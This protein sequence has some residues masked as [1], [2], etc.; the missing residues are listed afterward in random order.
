[1]INGEL[2][3]VAKD[4]AVALEYSTSSTQQISNLI[5]HVPEE[6]KGINKIN[7]LG[8]NQEM[9][10]LTENGLYE[11]LMQSRKLIAKQLG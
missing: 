6:C 1:M 3:F 11:V 4:V 10:F 9:W 2:H 7:T 5:S 8:G